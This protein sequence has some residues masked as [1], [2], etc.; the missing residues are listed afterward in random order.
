MLAVKFRVRFGCRTVFRT[1][2]DSKCFFFRSSVPIPNPNPNVNP[3]GLVIRIYVR[4]ENRPPPGGTYQTGTLLRL[5][6]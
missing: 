6:F 2:V 5:D 3:G 1:D 4:S